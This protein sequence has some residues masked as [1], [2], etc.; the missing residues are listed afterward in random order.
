MSTAVLEGVRL[1][2]DVEGSGEPLLM[3]QGLGYGRTGWGPAARAARAALQ[4]RDVFDNRGFGESDVPP[5]PYTTSQLARD[6]LAVLD[7]AEIDTA[8]VI[9]ISL[10]GMIAQELVLAAA[11]ACAQ[12]R[13]LLDDSGRAASRCRCPSRRWR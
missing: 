10:G 3:I 1:A 4:G 6:A 2:Y 12:A 8:H 5:G 13:A 9:G 11:R 7:A